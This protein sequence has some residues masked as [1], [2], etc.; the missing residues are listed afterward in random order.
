MQRELA[1]AAALELVGDALRLGDVPALHPELA[2]ALAQVD[3]RA[4]LPGFVGARVRR[5]AIIPASLE[6]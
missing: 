6:P 2:V 1:L 3:A 5:V 4:E